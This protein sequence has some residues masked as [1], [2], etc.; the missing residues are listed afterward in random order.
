MTAD[1]KLATNY[2]NQTL[3]TLEALQDDLQGIANASGV[4]FTNGIAVVSEKLGEA[5]PI[6]EANI[7]NIIDTQRRRRRS[8]VESRVS[9]IDF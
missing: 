6:V 4:T 3:G 1:G 9:T 7:G 8:L 5:N 2:L